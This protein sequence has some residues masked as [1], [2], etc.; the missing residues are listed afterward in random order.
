MATP[1]LV[2]I[3]R[4]SLPD[5]Y[6]PISSRRSPQLTNG[7]GV[8]GEAE[9]DWEKGMP[10]GDAFVQL[11]QKAWRIQDEKRRQSLSPRYVDDRDR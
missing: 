7:H 6:T 11:L 10:L 2:D 9:H 5:T 4:F 3:V 1:M 8:G